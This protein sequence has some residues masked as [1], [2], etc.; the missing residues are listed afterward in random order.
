M[1]V[2]DVLFVYLQGRA[3]EAKVCQA[4]LAKPLSVTSLDADLE[5]RPIYLQGK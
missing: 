2:K 5:R 3:F 1:R 4:Y